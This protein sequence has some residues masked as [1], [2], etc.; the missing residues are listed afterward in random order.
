MILPYALVILLAFYA[1]L[2]AWIVYPWAVVSLRQRLCRHRETEYLGQAIPLDGH[3]I[4]GVRCLSCDKVEYSN[5]LGQV[6]WESQ[7]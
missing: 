1:A 2:L 7:E 5:G 4:V 6:V 3:R